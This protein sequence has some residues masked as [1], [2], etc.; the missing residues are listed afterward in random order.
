M[1]KLMIFCFKLRLKFQEYIW[2]TAHVH[3][4]IPTHNHPS[5]RT[6]DNLKASFQAVHEPVTLLPT[7]K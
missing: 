7:T 5:P 1:H 4:F 3:A 2:M 6:A